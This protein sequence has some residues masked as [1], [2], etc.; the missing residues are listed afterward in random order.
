MAEAPALG[1]ITGLLRAIRAGDRAAE[2]VLVEK[3]YPELHRIAGALMR[4]ERSA[5]TLQTTALVHE[6][7]LRLTNSPS[8]E[9]QD[10]THFFAIAAHVMR[11]ILVD[12]ARRRDAEKR[13]GQY[14]AIELE[15]SFLGV[16]TD[17]DQVLEVDAL[18]RKLSTY[19]ARQER[20]VEMKMFS[21]MTDEEVA[22][23]LSVNVRTVKRDWKMAKAWLHGQL[24]RNR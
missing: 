16:Q 5:H 9:I 14:A 1:D 11:R 23:V 20:V 8:A 6:A 21:G 22:Q 3:L 4:R 15:D 2:A 24:A 18:L 17:L 10:R 12:H 19:D 13:E 7:Y